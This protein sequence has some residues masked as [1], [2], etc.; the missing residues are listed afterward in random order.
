M[1]KVIINGEEYRAA[2]G[3]LLLDV[4]RRNRAHIGFVC[5]GNGICTTCECKVL[6]GAEALSPLSKAETDWLPPSRLRRGYRLGCQTAVETETETVEVITRVEEFKRQFLDSINPSRGETLGDG[7][8]KFWSNLSLLTL[9]HMAQS[10]PGLTGTIDRLGIVKFLFPW[11]DVNVWLREGG[12]V[13]DGEMERG[14]RRGPIPPAEDGT[15]PPANS[16]YDDFLPINGIGAAFNT[17]L[18]NAGITTYE[19]LARLSVQEIAAILDIDPERI[20]RDRWREQATE[21]AKTKV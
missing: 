21:L 11:N 8:I 18:H 16:L 17:R 14:D 4:A 2:T 9:E 7:M 12:R 19:Q 20:I 6:A 1:A 5:G 15:I 10:V 3:E 13:I